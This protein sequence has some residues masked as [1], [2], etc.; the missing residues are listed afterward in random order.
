[1]DTCATESAW[2]IVRPSHGCPSDT[3]RRAGHR[4]LRQRAPNHITIPTRLINEFEIA[5]VALRE[6][7]IAGFSSYYFVSPISDPNQE[8]SLAQDVSPTIAELLVEEISKLVPLF[9]EDPTDREMSK[10]NAACCVI[11]PTGRVCGRIFGD[12]KA[13]GAWC[14][15]IVQRKVNQVWRTGYATGRFE[16]LVYSGKLDDGRFGINRPDFIGWEGGVPLFLPDGTLIAAA[17]SG[18][19]GNKDVEILQRA[20]AKIPDLRVA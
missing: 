17:F 7:A 16:E 18:F 9:L 8:H 19:R 12:D 20:A 5:G 6:L 14:F 15:G 13:K 10:S 4:L 11:D 1:M 2:N 3:T